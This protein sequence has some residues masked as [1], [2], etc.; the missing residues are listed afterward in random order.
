MMPL[1]HDRLKQIWGYSEFRFPQFEIVQAI[2]ARQDALIVLPTGGG[3]SLCFQLPAIMQ[4]G[5]TIVVSPLVALMENQ[6][7]ELQQKRIPAAL[8]HSELSSWQRKQ[9]LNAIA[10]HRLLYLSP[11]T[12]LSPPVWQRLINPQLKI[13]SLII[14]EAHC[15]AQWGETF[16]PVYY[17]LGAARSTL[18]NHRNRVAIAAFTATANP[19]TQATIQRLLQLEAPQCFR[20]SPYRANLTLKV[21]PVSTPKQRRQK[22]LEV[23]RAQTGSG[24]VYVRSRRDAEEL[25]EWLTQQGHRTAAYHAGL[26]STDRR[27]IEQAWLNDQLRFVVATCAFGLG[28]NKAATR[29]VVHYHAPLLMSE[30]VQEIG[31][32]GRDGKAAIAVLLKSSWLDPEDRQRWQFFETQERNQAIKAQQ[33][34]PKL[35]QQGNIDVVAREFKGAAIALSLLHNANQLAW[36]DPFHYEIQSKQKR[37]KTS[38]NS[39]QSMKDYLSTKGCRWRF[40]LRSF[41]F[42]QDAENFACGHCD[43]CR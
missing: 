18:S 7:Q 17:R 41:G 25:V 8:L 24:L 35:P 36:T 12:L 16:R 6:V 26:K 14:D 34:I 3:K 10:T 31:R 23:I 37:L 1:L 20:V 21:Q 33:L 29:W 11:E 27:Q 5:L 40:V 4:Q 15:L 42:E 38:H 2:L 30:Y 43:H 22:L 32:A 39:T 19:A 13:N 9:V 28:V